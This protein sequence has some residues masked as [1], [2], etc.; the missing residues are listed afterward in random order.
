MEPVVGLGLRPGK[1]NVT[2]AIRMQ[3]LWR[4]V[5]GVVV[6][7]IGVAITIGTYTNATTSVWMYLVMYG[8]IV[9]GMVQIGRGLAL[10]QLR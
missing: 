7:G 5:I 10:L 6:M 9:G 3:A 8:P 4:I 1:R 2:R